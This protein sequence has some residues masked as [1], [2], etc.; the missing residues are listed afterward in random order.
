MRLGIVLEPPF[1]EDAARVEALG[2]DLAWVDEASAPAPLVTVAALAAATSGVRLAAALTAGAHPITLAEEAAVADHACGGRLVLV[3]AADEPALLAETVELVLRSWAARPFRHH[4]QR[5]TAP[6]GM[7]EHEHAEDRVRITPPP[8]QLQPTVWLGGQASGAVAA[9]V[10][11]APV[12]EEDGLASAFWASAERDGGLAV[13]SLRRPGRVRVEVDHDGRV[14]SADLVSSLRARQDAWGLDVA[15]L[16]LSGELER[17]ARERA[18][19]TI[20]TA[21]RPALQLDRLP[22]GLAEHWEVNGNV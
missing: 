6:A 12:L 17:A 21:V 3:L 13:L 7:P 10:G 4:G 19:R 15:V 20:A 8:A 11:L 5:W 9:A 14:D 18:L 2:F 16:E 22:P 1:A